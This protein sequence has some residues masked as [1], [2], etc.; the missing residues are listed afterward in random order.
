MEYEDGVTRAILEYHL[1]LPPPLEP[2]AAKLQ[3]VNLRKKLGTDLLNVEPDQIIIE[4]A[5]P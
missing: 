5:A 4:W 2:A 1:A 3:A